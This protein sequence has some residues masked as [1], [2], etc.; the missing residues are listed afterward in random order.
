MC[1]FELNKEEQAQIDEMNR[2]VDR[3]IAAA[4]AAKPINELSDDELEDLG[5]DIAISELLGEEVLH[6]KD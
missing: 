3:K 5:I 2:R 6:E 1:Q 4:D